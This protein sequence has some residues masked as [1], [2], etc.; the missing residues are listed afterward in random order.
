AELARHFQEAGN[1][2]KVVEYL[3]RASERATRLFAFDEAI[4]R[5]HRALTIVQA[6]SDPIERMQ[7]VFR[8]HMGLAEARRKAGHFELALESFQK[9]AALARD[10][11]SAEELARAAL[12][13]EETRW[14]ANLP[15]KPAALLLTEALDKLT[16]E[17]GVLRVRVWLNLARTRMPISSPEEVEVI[18]QQALEKARRVDDPVAL[19]EAL[20]LSVRGNRRPEQSDER[21]AMLNEMLQLA[22]TI[23][24]YE[25]SRDAYGFRLLEYLERGEIDTYL[26]DEQRY[27]IPMSSRI[28]QPFYDYVATLYRIAPAQLAGRFDE[29][30]ELVGQALEIGRQMRVENHDGV[31]GM[32]MFTI[33]REQGRLK[34][35][36]PVLR[37]IVSQN[38]ATAIWR[39][40]LALMYA[41]LDMRGEAEVEFEKLALNDFGNLSRDG[42][43]V[44][45]LVFLS[46]VCAYLGDR[47]RAAILYELLRPYDGRNIVIGFYSGSLGATARYLALLALTMSDWQTAERHF[48][49]A[50][51]MN[52]RMGGWPWLAHTQYEYGRMLLA[53]GGSQDRDRAQTLLSAA[54]ETATDLGMAGLIADIEIQNNGP[55]T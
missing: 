34:E 41:E 10:S 53:C 8:L 40:G 20:Y 50:L 45:N 4:E 48:E 43:W 26:A 33:R 28:G 22:E 55:S 54:L 14:R 6:L 3:Y 12:G 31:Y 11:G 9:A 47:E 30:E 13:Y 15:V 16:S 17:E 37:L 19:F 46:E 21:L 49:D 42:L 36:A 18:L 39:P 2:S 1:Q 38:P 44:T 29:A 24:S 27:M 5:F 51:A 23:G 7:Q 25:L 32:Q 52:E 35:L